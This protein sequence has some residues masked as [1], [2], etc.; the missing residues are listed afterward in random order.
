MS[1]LSHGYF[2]GLLLVSLQ[3]VEHDV[4]VDF[5]WLVGSAL[6]P[7]LTDDHFEGPSSYYRN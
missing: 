1:R 4:D 2:E 3:N 5:G 7:G 6:L